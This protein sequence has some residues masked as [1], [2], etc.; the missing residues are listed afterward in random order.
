MY[1]TLKFYFVVNLTRTGKKGKELKGNLIEQIR[2]A[3]DTYSTVYV[4]A[5]ENMRTE[6]LQAARA[7]LKGRARFFIGKNRVMAKALG[8][9]PEDE[10][11]EG[12]YELSSKLSGEVGL[13][14]ARE[15]E[16]KGYTL[17]AEEGEALI[18]EEELISYLD[19]L[20]Q[21]DYARPGSLATETVTV[22]AGPLMTRDGLPVPSNLE[23]QVRQCGLPVTLIRGVVVVPEG[24]ERVICSEGDKL[25]A[26]QA[27][28][29][30]LLNYQ[31]VTFRIRLIARYRDGVVADLENDAESDE[32]GEE[33]D[34]E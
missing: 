31:M 15:K 33:E 24:P 23:G 32:E 17:N 16:C 25:N 28:L 26:D 30:K 7:E 21:G 20:E 13:L 4:F 6:L 5:I 34:M 19:S 14:F 1:L 27:R 10:Q 9:T 18:S 3:L 12:I 22:P 11:R 8:T 29:L 2:A